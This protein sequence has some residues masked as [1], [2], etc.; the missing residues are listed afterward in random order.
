MSQ[1][2]Q[3][4]SRYRSL[5][6]SAAA[7]E[8]VSLLAQAEA[9]E[10]SYL[11]F[12]DQLAEYEMV[13]RQHKRLTRNL[14]LAAFPSE[15]R[16]EGFDYRHQSTISKRQV[17]ALLDF[18]FIDERN[19][20]VFIGPPGVGKTHL[21]IGIGHKAVEAGYR[22]LFRNALDL[23]EE[24]E[25]AEMKGELKKRVNQLAKHD[26]LIIDE[27]GYLPMTRQARFNLFQLINSLYE[28]RSI[29]LTTNKDFTNWGEFF[30]DDNVAVPIIDRIIHHS[31]IFMLGGESY[32]LKQ[33]TKS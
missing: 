30:H 21:A 15:K 28:Y 18:G 22:V 31:H 26:L 24:L 5:R 29:I 11:S 27:L 13:Q 32:R 3:T 17:N 8:L 20:L 25:L 23:V 2:E 6:M 14:K 1:L 10:A 4:Q 19:N 16:L 33:K 9:N 12:A 7:D